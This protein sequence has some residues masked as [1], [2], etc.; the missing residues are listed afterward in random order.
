[1][2]I[3][4]HLLPSRQQ[5]MGAEEF[6]VE[7]MGQRIRVIVLKPQSHRLA[8]W[9]GGIPQQPIASG[10]SRRRSQERLPEFVSGNPRG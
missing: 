6:S 9:P 8:L 2:E 10:K 5:G 1:M 3:C 4:V 7:P